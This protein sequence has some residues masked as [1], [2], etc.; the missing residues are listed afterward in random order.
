[1]P[2]TELQLTFNPSVLA[3]QTEHAARLEQMS[4]LI[5]IRFELSSLS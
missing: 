5:R 2:S 4:R 1:M 3:K